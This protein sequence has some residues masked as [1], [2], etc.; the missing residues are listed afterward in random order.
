MST[1]LKKFILEALREYEEE[2]PRSYV[3]VKGRPVTLRAGD[4]KADIL[5]PAIYDMIAKSYEPIGGHAKIAS[6][7]NV[8]NEY[9]EWVVADVDDDPDPDVAVVGQQAAAGGHKIGATATDGSVKAKSY[10]N[11]LKKR[12]F[13]QDWW[14]EVSGAPAHIAINK[15]GVKPVTD[16]K[17]VERLLGKKV[18]WY[19]KHPEGKFPGIDGWY[20]RDIGGHE[21][22]KIIVGSVP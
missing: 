20:S 7:K 18:K 1:L 15:L 9:P 21:H 6:P 4:P 13:G 19:G 14:G 10:M 8:G 11:T 16:Q 5:E 12:L 22:V 2:D 3:G 17:T